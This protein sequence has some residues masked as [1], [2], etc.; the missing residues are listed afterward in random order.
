MDEPI[1]IVVTT[2]AELEQY[3]QSWFPDWSH[4]T[5]LE[6]SRFRIFFE[7]TQHRA[8][9][10]NQIFYHIAWWKGEAIARQVN[11]ITKIAPIDSIYPN[12]FFR[13][14]FKP[15]AT[16]IVIVSPKA[17]S[18]DILRIYTRRLVSREQDQRRIAR[19]KGLQKHSKTSR[20][21]PKRLI[22]KS[23]ALALLAQVSAAYEGSMDDLPT[24][25]LRHL[26]LDAEYF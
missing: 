21:T 18:R 24:P 3:C 6:R 20:P 4:R 1:M 26:H 12:E 13:I 10:Q 8:H 2:W 23:P 22:S 5:E 19:K 14:V 16:A 11:A 7:D 15:K 9:R 17:E 25:S